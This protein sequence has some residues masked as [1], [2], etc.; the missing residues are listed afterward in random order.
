MKDEILSTKITQLQDKITDWAKAKGFSDKFE[1]WSYSDFHNDE[2]YENFACVTV[3]RI[4]GDPYNF[5]NGYG[6]SDLLDEFEALID[7]T[8][9]DYEMYDES[10]VQFFCKD[11]LLNQLYLSYFEWE[12]ISK[13]IEPDYTSLY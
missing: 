3:L 9:F 5:L 13:L 4:Y 1:F 11:E 12:W 10:V 6:D 8:E 7:A 2:P